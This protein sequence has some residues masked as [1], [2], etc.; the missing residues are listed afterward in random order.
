MKAEL[1]RV[2]RVRDHPALHTGWSTLGLALVA[3]GTRASNVQQYP[4]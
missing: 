4:A 2:S 3:K 1:I